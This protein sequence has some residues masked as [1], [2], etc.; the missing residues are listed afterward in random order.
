[1]SDQNLTLRN[2]DIVEVDWKSAKSLLS[3]IRRAVFVVEQQV[4]VEEEWDGRD[5]ECWHWL[6]SDP[7]GKPIGT[8]RL[9]PEGQIGRLA[10]LSEYRGQS[11][12]A[13]LLERAVDKAGKLGFGSIF[14][15]AQSYALEFY[16]KAGFVEEGEEFLEAGIQH[17]KMVRQLPLSD[18]P[19]PGVSVPARPTTLDIRTFDIA[20]VPW[21][22]Q[23]AVIRGIRKQVLV[24][25]LKLPD[26]LVAD[27]LD[28]HDSETTHWV[29]QLDEDHVDDRGEN[30]VVGAIRMTQEGI[31]SRL[32]V[33]P[34]HRGKGIGHSLLESATAKAGRFGLT[35]VSLGALATLTDFYTSA[36]FRTN[37]S[38]YNHNDI[39]HQDF[40]K[41]LP[42]EG[43]PAAHSLNPG[44]VLK[45]QDDQA[46]NEPGKGPPGNRL[47]ETDQMF[48]LRK[49]DDFQQMILQMC[50][51]ARTSI[52]L[53]SPLLDHKLYDN[54]ELK[55]YFSILARKNRYTFIEILIYDAHRMV[56]N[57]HT[58]MELSR[59]LSSSITIRLVHPDYQQSNQEYL[60]VDKA[61]LVYR[62][63]HETYEGYA[64]FKD[65]SQVDRL[66]REFQRAWE[67]SLEDPNLR[68]LYV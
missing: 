7:A 47:G 15:N 50:A 41:S 33:L 65:I 3:D 8:A 24:E 6:A 39:P 46:E 11:I 16:R 2:F 31:I 34:E 12:G 45:D 9:L 32:A 67:T 59:R 55:E 26:A 22:Q 43:K 52:R 56:K 66:T 20:E 25:E 13:A 51:Q 37:G 5:E 60:L 58:L 54:Q 44:D 19:D 48:V 53:H 4:P 21:P 49:E 1:M 68:Q 28:S 40:I 27:D 10:V 64:N 38:I 23:E 63:N 57:G 14:L 61:G 36:G 42:L 17:R 62:Q 29:A 35:Q 18:R 30:Q